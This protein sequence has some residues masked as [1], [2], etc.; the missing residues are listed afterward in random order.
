MYNVANKK[1]DVF[2]NTSGNILAHTA[3][4]VPRVFIQTALAHTVHPSHCII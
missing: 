4:A 3:P 2:V 1:A